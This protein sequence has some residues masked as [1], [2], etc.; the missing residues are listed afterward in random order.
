MENFNKTRLFATLLMVFTSIAAFAQIPN[1][2]FETW[3]G[4]SCLG[5]LT[6]YND[7]NGWGSIN[8]LTCPGGGFTCVEANAAN[9]HSGSHAL[10]LET[11]SIFGQLAP[12]IIATG[13]IN[14]STQNVDGGFALNTRPDKLI[15]WIKYTPANPDTF[16]ID[17]D[18]Y[19]GATTGTVIATGELRG[20]SAISTYT[21]VIVNIPYTSAA[22]ADSAKITI[23]SSPG[24]NGTAGTKMWVDDL[25]FVYCA[26]FGAT[27]TPVNA[28]CTQSTGSITLGAPVNGTAPYNYLWSNGA[29][30]TSLSNLAPGTYKYTMTDANTCASTDSIVIAAVNVPFTV[31]ATGSLTSCTSNT[32]TVTA[33]VSAGNSPYTYSWSNNSTANPITGLGAGNYPVTV[34]D[35]HGCTTSASGSVTTPNGPSATDVVT[36]IGC[37]GDSTGTI[38]VTVNGGTAPIS[39]AWSNT[40]TSLNLTGIPAGT[41]N[42]VINDANN[43]SFTISGTVSQ[44]A[45]LVARGSTASYILRCFG[46]STGGEGVFINGGTGPFTILW[47]TGDTTATIQNLGAGIYSVVVTDSNMCTSSA[48]DTILQPTAVQVILTPTIATSS[49]ASDGTDI[50]VASGGT[51]PLTLMWN[52]G[53][54]GDTITHLSTA[55]YCVTV[56]D[57]N[58]CSATA[59]DS[60]GF[61]PDTSIGINSIL[62]AQVKVYPN[63]ASN[64]L[65]I[66]TGSANGKFQFTVYSLDGRLVEQIMVTGDKSLIQLNRFADG[67]YTYQLR[68]VVSGGVNYGKLEIQR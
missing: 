14:Q 47:N 52:T 66:E 54:S 45:Q 15:G 21:K 38:T 64:Q 12:G 34:T 55:T 2:G 16:S 29:T 65:T 53:A 31:N 49:T 41:Y 18:I 23:L 10:E 68:D 32:G 57:A 46:D 28:N 4:G 17:I 67:F 51:A 33:A 58:F 27:A 20:W 6:T 24:Q 22:A 25:S 30:T 61:V 7:P 1:P 60:V 8:V 43:C 63:P 5:G 37:Y 48:S 13:V 3:T 40:A 44:P 26:G 39:Y 62:L 11:I 9:S 42:L 19:S 56:S 59:C 35:A 36:N 50:A